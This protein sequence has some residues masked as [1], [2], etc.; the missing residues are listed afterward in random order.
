MRQPTEYVR[1]WHDINRE[2]WRAA[3]NGVS[4]KPF[5]RAELWRR[6]DHAR[7]LEKS[8]SIRMARQKTPPCAI[9]KACCWLVE[10]GALSPGGVHMPQQSALDPENAAIPNIWPESYPG[11][12]LSEQA[13]KLEHTEQKVDHYE[14]FV[15]AFI[16]AAQAARNVG[17]EPEKIEFYFD[18][19]RNRWLVE[20]TEQVPF[21]RISVNFF[22]LTASPKI[23]NALFLAIVKGNVMSRRMVE[24]YAQSVDAQ[25]LLAVYTEIS[26]LKVHDAYD[27]SAMFDS[28]NA[29][30][31]NSALPK[32]MLAWTTRANYRTLGTYNFHWDI[33]CLSRILNDSRVPEVAVRYVL[34]HEMLH[35]KHGLQNV[36]GRSFAHTPEFRRD[37]MRF[38]GWEEASAIHQKLRDIVK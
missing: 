7:L 14:Q 33:I 5:V 38:K 2:L 6:V 23:W 35:I 24:R 34:Y 9:Y 8:A 21:K 4:P 15:H 37:E 36:A 31:F 20:G 10:S 29:E 19:S 32:P 3:V 12:D 25:Q 11:V 26:P 22:Y 13:D 18:F 17:L 28:L 16:F 1:L 30:Y 27:L